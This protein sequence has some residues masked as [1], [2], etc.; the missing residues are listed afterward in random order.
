LEEIIQ[1]LPFHDKELY[2]RVLQG[3]KVREI[4][5][6]TGEPLGTVGA[7]IS[8]LKDRLRENLRGHG[9]L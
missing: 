6:R 2:M 9:C 3:L 8:R 4:A 5:E 1:K 7:R